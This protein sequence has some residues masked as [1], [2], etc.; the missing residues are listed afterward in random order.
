M[1]ATRIHNWTAFNLV[2]FKWL[3]ALGTCNLFV[4]LFSDI[5]QDAG[6]CL[7]LLVHFRRYFWKGL[8]GD[9]SRTSENIRLMFPTIMGF[10]QVAWTSKQT[11]SAWWD[12]PNKEQQVLTQSNLSLRKQAHL[13]PLH[14]S[15]C[16]LIY[17]F[18]PLFLVGVDTDLKLLLLLW[19]TL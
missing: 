14:K 4:H 19:N 1:P 18:D 16:R 7:S 13:L 8:R 2:Y 17:S 5:N 11:H 6:G 12:L 9:G 3:I 10:Q 15:K